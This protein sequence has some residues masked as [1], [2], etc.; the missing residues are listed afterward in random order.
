MSPSPTDW[1]V[2]LSPGPGGTVDDLLAMPYSLDVWQ[3]DANS[4]VAAA[5]EATLVEIERRNLA[6]VERMGTAA[7]FAAQAG[8][9]G[10]GK[11]RTDQGQDQDQDQ[12][13]KKGMGNPP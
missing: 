10:A 13:G 9:T 1:I 8:E 6:C 12:A 7:E 2:R 5:P 4:L 3:R 11:E